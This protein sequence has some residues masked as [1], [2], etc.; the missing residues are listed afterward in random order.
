MAGEPP[1]LN[2]IS[3]KSNNSIYPVYFHAP[4]HSIVWE[5]PTADF[6]KFPGLLPL[7]VLGQ[8]DNPTQTL[9]FVSS[10]IDR[11]EDR[12]QKSNIAAAASV[13][14]GFFNWCS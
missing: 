11:I 7:P 8:N 4:R 9:R 1:A 14:G 10:V 3:E 5:Q 6:L 2:K 13:L 12:R